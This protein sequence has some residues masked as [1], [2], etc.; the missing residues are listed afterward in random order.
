MSVHSRRMPWASQISWETVS[1]KWFVRSMQRNQQKS[2]SSSHWFSASSRAARFRAQPTPAAASSPS[3]VASRTSPKV[4]APWS[5]ELRRGGAFPRAAGA[6]G[7][8]AR[9]RKLRAFPETADVPGNRGRSRPRRAFPAAARPG[10]GVAAAR[11]PASCVASP[12]VPDGRTCLR[13]RRPDRRAAPRAFPG[14][15]GAAIA[16]FH[17]RAGGG[18]GV[19][20]REDHDAVP[21]P[22]EA[23]DHLDAVGRR[24]EARGAAEVLVHAVAEHDEDRRRVVGRLERD[25]RDG[26]VAELD[27]KRRGLGRRVFYRGVDESLFDRGVATPPGATIRVSSAASPR[28]DGR[29]PA[30]RRPRSADEPRR[31]SRRVRG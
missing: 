12:G 7:S 24:A 18:H 6:P 29:S 20:G 10:R 2:A 9:S 3:R 13:A 16:P 11:S 21:A 8:R 15:G 25:G 1:A 28:S 30:S 26:A 31:A 19:E 27:A 22:V 5:G 14:R 4:M 17:H 23:V